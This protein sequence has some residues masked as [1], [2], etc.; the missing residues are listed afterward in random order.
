MAP[1]KKLE[2]L[3]LKKIGDHFSWNPRGIE[4]P[5]A[6]CDLA[7]LEKA[8]H[9]PNFPHHFDAQTHCVRNQQLSLACRL[10]FVNSENHVFFEEF[11]DSERSEHFG[12]LEI[13]RS[14]HR[15]SIKLESWIL[16]GFP[17]HGQ[18]SRFDQLRCRCA[19]NIWIQLNQWKYIFNKKQWLTVGHR[20][21]NR[22][23]GKG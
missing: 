20:N 10:A 4:A 14:E 11:D 12:M 2:G 22:F 13:S 19:L 7:Y 3:S 23:S 1:Q 5:S 6:N 16:K 18:K 15:E 21:G 8:F 17:F 9:I